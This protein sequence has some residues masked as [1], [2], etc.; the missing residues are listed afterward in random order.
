MRNFIGISVITVAICTTPEVGVAQIEVAT[1]SQEYPDP[2]C[3]RPNIKLIKP[4][5][6]H[7]G[8]MADS[9]AVGSYN[10]KVKAYN[11]EAG[12]YNSCMHSYID[13]ANGELKRVQSDANDKIKQITD[14]AN[15]RLR[16]IEGK[17]ANAVKDANEVADEEAVAHK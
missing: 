6:N 1:P 2:Q 9:G 13:N 5:Y 4:E 12:A 15:A 11:R 17:I 16:H 3:T 10:S 8:N 14:S 7:A